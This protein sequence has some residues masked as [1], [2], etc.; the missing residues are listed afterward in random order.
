MRLKIEYYGHIREE[1]GTAKEEYDTNS[2]TIRELLLEL[3][4]KHRLHP[5]VDPY[6]SLFVVAVN[7]VIVL[8]D[9]FTRT[10]IFKNGD[11]VAIMPPFAGG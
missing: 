8:P 5:L 1:V 6:R 7:S 9:L 4:E 2:M 3:Q 10:E 11:T